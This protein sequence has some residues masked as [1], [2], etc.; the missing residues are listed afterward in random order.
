[1]QQHTNSIIHKNNARTSTLKI[2]FHHL[3]N[4]IPL[5][6]IFIYSPE[7]GHEQVDEHGANHDGVDRKEQQSHPGVLGAQGIIEGVALVQ[8]LIGHT[9]GD[10]TFKFVL[11]LS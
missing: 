3:L 4:F 11:M 6:F 2:N 9:V 1:M 5:F 10:L 7:D 8:R